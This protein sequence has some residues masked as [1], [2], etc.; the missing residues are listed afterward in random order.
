MNYLLDRRMHD[1]VGTL[2]SGNRAL[3]EQQVTLGIDPDHV[4]VQSRDVVGTHMAGHL[5]ALPDLARIL[6]LA[7][8]A[9][10]AVAD[11]H[12]VAGTQAAAASGFRVL[13]YSGVAALA[14]AV[15]V[16]VFLLSRHG[17]FSELSAMLSIAAFMFSLESGEL[18]M[19][20]AVAITE[21][22][23]RL[24]VNWILALH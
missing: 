23:A 14:V 15:G 3:D 24:L 12:T 7:G 5:L 11:R 20:N 4:E 10:A 1:D 8:R 19:A 17:G 18:A 16:A 2:V 13:L 21:G 9:V 6:A 22:N